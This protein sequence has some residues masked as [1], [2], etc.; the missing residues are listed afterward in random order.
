VQTKR[1]LT[2][3]T[4]VGFLRITVL[5]ETERFDS[6]SRAVTTRVVEGLEWLDESANGLVDDGIESLI[7]VSQPREP[8]E[9]K[10]DEAH[11]LARDR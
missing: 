5:D 6:G 9:A 2:A 3:G 1:M 7:E 11:V 8:T 10:R 4:L